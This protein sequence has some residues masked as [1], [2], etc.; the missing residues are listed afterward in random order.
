MSKL[1]GYAMHRYFPNGK[2]TNREDFCWTAERLGFRTTGLPG[3][4]RI[5]TSMCGTSRHSPCIRVS[6]FRRKFFDPS[7]TS[8]GSFAI[9]IFG[10]RKVRAGTPRNFSSKEMFAIRCWLALNEK[11]LLKRW[12]SDT[13]DSS[14][15]CEQ[16]RKLPVPIP[17]W[18]K[19]R[20]SGRWPRI[21]V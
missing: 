20:I 4:I 6:N 2:L 19:S 3:G 15:L 18:R 9:C 13:M 14:E 8:G 12:T 5:W 7:C 10:T 11:L 17:L 16:V 21:A 1:P